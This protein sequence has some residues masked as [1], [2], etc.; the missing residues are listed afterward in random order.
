MMVGGFWL[1]SISIGLT[2]G[3]FSSII[4]F[5][6]SAHTGHLQIHRAGY[7]EN[8]SLQST[9]ADWPS[10]EKSLRT[11][12]DIVS[13]CPRLYASALAF[14][15]SK[16]VGARLI[17]VDPR[18]EAET[19]TLR[20]KVVSGTYFPEKGSRD[21]LV[22]DGIAK[23]LDLGIGSEVA[24][25]SQGADGSVANDLFRVAGI[26]GASEGGV[27]RSLY[28]RLADAQSFLAMEGRYHEVAII[29]KDIE[30]ASLTAQ[31]LGARLS[32]PD[33][34][35]QPW[36]VI[37]KDF[38]RAMQ[39]NIKYKGLVQIIFQFLVALGVLNT[40][41]MNLLERVPEYG[42]MKALGTRPSTLTG[43]IFFEMVLLALFSIVPGTLLA[44]GTN[45]YLEVHGFPLPH[46]FTY[47]GR[48]FSAIYGHVSPDIFLVP[49]AIILGIAALVTL[50]AA[51]RV[52]KLTP[53][54]ALRRA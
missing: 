40:V 15:G 22:G 2:E 30:T 9:L 53:L 34:D 52:W 10:L 24:L 38:Y 6:T 28:L 46:T 17:G 23:A 18:L 39:V 37:E 49:G 54:E 21:L 8:P 48:V 33:L 50:P 14:C 35:V 13:V 36:Q 42:L 45:A 41:L 47:G 20:S 5:F 7:L 26:L 31:S 16:T 43:M 12:P 19:C 3:S 29:L 11:E 51:W 27:D 4:R 44:W 25:I 32:R 1:C